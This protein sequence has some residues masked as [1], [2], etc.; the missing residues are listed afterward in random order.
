MIVLKALALSADRQIGMSACGGGTIS[1]PCRGAWNRC[2]VVAAASGPPPLQP[3]GGCH[4]T[5]SFGAE[6]P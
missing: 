1:R 4:G 5:A 6:R 2:A 3:S